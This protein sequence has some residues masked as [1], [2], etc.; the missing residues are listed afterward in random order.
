MVILSL[1]R[2]TLTMNMYNNLLIKQSQQDYTTLHY[3][4]LKYK[5]KPHRARLP[6]A[7]EPP[8]RRTPQARH[9]PKQPS[10]RNPNPATAAK[11]R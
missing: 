7:I 10:E 1:L 11:P 6:P 2:M 5:R 9:H 4:T 8:P 3:A